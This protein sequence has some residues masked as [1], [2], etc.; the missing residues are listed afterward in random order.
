MHVSL[1]HPPP[2]TCAC[3]ALPPCCHPA[4]MLSGQLA[5][6]YATRLSGYFRPPITADYRFWLLGKTQT[7]RCGTIQETLQQFYIGDLQRCYIGDTSQRPPVCAPTATY[8]PS[9]ARRRRLRGVLHE[10]QRQQLRPHQARLAGR[11]DLGPLQVR[12]AGQPTSISVSVCAGTP[13][14]CLGSDTPGHAC[15]CGGWH[16]TGTRRSG[17]AG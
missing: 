3:P 10:Q 6:Y 8:P 5:Y 1:T 11:M 7:R 16:V 13:T 17:Q 9:P 12:E 14:S 15:M 2:P 4:G